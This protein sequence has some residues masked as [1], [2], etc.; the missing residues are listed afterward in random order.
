MVVTVRASAAQTDKKSAGL[1]A[2]RVD[3]DRRDYDVGVAGE[4]AFA[5]A[6]EQMRQRCRHVRFHL[7]N[8]R[9]HSLAQQ[10]REAP[11]LIRR[12]RRWTN[13]RASATPPL[14]KARDWRDREM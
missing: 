3:G 10:G 6:G 14:S 13:S 1:R 8:A 9:E 5:G 4:G 7:P 2:A 11:M 12:D